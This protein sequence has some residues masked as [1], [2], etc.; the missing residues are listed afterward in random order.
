MEE[1]DL[2]LLRTIHLKAS[3]G[4]FLGNE[5]INKIAE[6]LAQFPESPNPQKKP[7]KTTSY[8]EDL[9]KWENNLACRHCG[10]DDKETFGYGRTVAN[11]DVYF[12]EECQSEVLMSKK[13]NEDNY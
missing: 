2:H 4:Y 11:G 9:E 10:N 6:R 3:N 7:V 1:Q 5:L 13:P 12:C 8:F